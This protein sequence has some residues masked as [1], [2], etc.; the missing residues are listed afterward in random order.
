M[1]KTIK[2]KDMV[3]DIDFEKDKINV[4]LWQKDDSI[5]SGYAYLGE[6]TFRVEV[7]K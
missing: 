1:K 2:N 4:S 5:E 6:H 3:I 7:K